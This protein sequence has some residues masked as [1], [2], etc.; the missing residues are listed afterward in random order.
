MK[1]IDVPEPCKFVYESPTN[2]L[3]I[4]FNLLRSLSLNGLCFLDTPYS[5]L[6]IVFEGT[7]QR[8]IGVRE[9]KKFFSLVYK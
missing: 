2:L 6:L 4:S 1:R 5:K 8:R 9:V 7:K 3:L